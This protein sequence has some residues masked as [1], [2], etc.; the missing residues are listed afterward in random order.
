MASIGNAAER[1]SS[2]STMARARARASLIP[3][4]LIEARHVANNVHAG[5]HGRR[6]RGIGE[7]FW[8]FRPYVEGENMASID[9]RRSARDDYVYIRD[10]EWQATH[11]VWIWIDESPSMLFKSKLATVSKQSRAVVLG[12]ALAELLARSGERIGLAG[13]TRPIVSRQGAERIGEALSL[14]EPQTTFPSSL[15]VTGRS[16]IVLFSDFLDDPQ[17]VATRLSTLART[18]IRGHLVQIVDPVEEVFPYAGRIEFSDPETGEKVTAGS[19]ASLRDSYS[20]LFRAHVA[21]IRKAATALGWSHTL[22][23]TDSLAS[24]A[25]TSLHIHMSQ[26]GGMR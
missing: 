5:W 25:L 6:K 26:N 14:A 11:L 7:N 4:L 24:Q 15:D 20:G 3:D 10:R 23:H 17:L 19:A 13:L 21:A 18:G 8:Q 1:E 9:W 2:Q 16:D 22:H 12:L